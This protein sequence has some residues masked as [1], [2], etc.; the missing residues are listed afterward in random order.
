MDED[1]PRFAGCPKHPASF[2]ETVLPLLNTLLG[3]R[4]EEP[5]R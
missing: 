3:S 2:M 1:K 5:N 4:V